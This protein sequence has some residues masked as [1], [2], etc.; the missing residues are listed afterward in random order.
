MKIISIANGFQVDYMINY[1]NSI[2]GKIDQIDFIGSDIYPVDK[3]PKKIKFINLRG[4]HEH[5]ASLFIKIKRIIKY[6]YHLIK[7]LKKNKTRGIIHL[8]W[9]K[10]YLFD[11]VIMPWY[12]KVIGYRVA[13]TVHDVIPHD[14]D[15]RVNRLLFQLIYN[16]HE[17]L[18]VHTEFIKNR[19]IDE[20][21][22]PSHK[23]KI[24]KH[25]VYQINDN[26]IIERTAAK[27]KIG[28]GK[29]NIVLLF[30]GYITYYKGLD[31]LLKVFNQLNSSKIKLIVAGEV[32]DSYMN[33]VNLLKKKYSEN[34]TYKLNYIND[35][36]LNDLFNATD[37]VV[38]PYREASQSGVL[39]MSYA[40][41]VPVLAPKLGGFPYDI[42]ENKTGILFEAD[43]EKS[44]YDNLKK[45]IDS[46]MH[47]NL[48]N[49]N[50]IRNY[51][52]INYSWTKSGSELIDFLT[53]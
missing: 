12:C 27:Q 30:F 3:I 21:N 46:I 17:R 10:F 44:F 34:I 31:L 33:E 41:G 38:L 28:I 43:N 29:E 1:L 39:F 4:G 18:I 9:L 49:R 15:T 37:I 14:K 20:F 19:L 47:N 45:T 5:D 13:Y 50:E 26:Q 16:L 48:L 24:I 11:G 32:K 7:Y 51:A 53:N 52:K 35:S 42:A 36:E 6:Y 25:G 23:I 2:A 22:I 40:Y 8:Q